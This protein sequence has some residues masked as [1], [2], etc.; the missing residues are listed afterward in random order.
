MKQIVMLGLV[1]FVLGA[2][3]GGA[4]GA[5]LGFVWIDVFHTGFFEG[6]FGKLVF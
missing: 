6:Y 3:T 1:G 4:I 2:I 5:G